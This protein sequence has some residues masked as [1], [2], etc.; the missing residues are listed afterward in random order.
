MWD[1]HSALARENPAIANGVI[2]ASVPP[3]TMTSAS[4]NAMSLDASPMLCAP[5]AH[6]VTQEC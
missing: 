4:P 2:A 6:A 1:V 5:V 3:A